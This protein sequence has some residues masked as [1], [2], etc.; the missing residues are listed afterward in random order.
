MSLFS[1]SIL[2]YGD[3]VWG[4]GIGFGGS[5]YQVGFLVPR[6]RIW[7]IFVRCVWGSRDLGV[8]MVVEDVA[9]ICVGFRK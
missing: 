8:M 3:E 2:R 6:H 7:C 9:F 1:W 4:C 5:W